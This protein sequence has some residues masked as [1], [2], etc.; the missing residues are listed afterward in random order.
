MACLPV[1][2]SAKKKTESLKEMKSTLKAVE[3]EWRMPFNEVLANLPVAGQALR[4]RMASSFLLLAATRRHLQSWE[5]NS[6]SK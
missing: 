4:L 3:K 2:A 1:G 5:W 6:A